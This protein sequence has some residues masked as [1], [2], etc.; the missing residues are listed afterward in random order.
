MSVFASAD[1]SWWERPPSDRV[2]QPDDQKRRAR[3]ALEEARRLGLPEAFLPP[4]TTEE[5]G[6]E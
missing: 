4:D 5:P 2:W 6:D 1:E 3:Q